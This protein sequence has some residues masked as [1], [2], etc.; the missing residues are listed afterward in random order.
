ML[1][2]VFLQLFGS[3][4]A[5][6]YV[7]FGYKWCGDNDASLSIQT[8]DGSWP[9]VLSTQEVYDAASAWSAVSSNFNYTQLSTNQV[10][11]VYVFSTSWGGAGS[12]Y[13]VDTSTPVNGCLQASNVTFNTVYSWNPPTTSCNGSTSWAPLYSVALHELGHAVGLDHS[14]SSSAIMYATMDLCAN[15]SW[16]QDDIDGIRAIYD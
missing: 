12:S 7:L 1:A 4:M 11:D 10:A 15:K 13:A 3:S 6:A 5:D 8:S 2:A 9:Y 16:T 14:G